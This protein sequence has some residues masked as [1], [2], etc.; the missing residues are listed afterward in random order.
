MQHRGGIGRVG[1]VGANVEAKLVEQF[2]GGRL[3]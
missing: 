2:A 3:V 1:M